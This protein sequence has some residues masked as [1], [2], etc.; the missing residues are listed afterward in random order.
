MTSVAEVTAR[1]IIRMSRWQDGSEYAARRGIAPVPAEERA[2][3]VDVL[4]P[5]AVVVRARMIA[6]PKMLRID[7]YPFG[8][9]SI[10]RAANA[11]DLEAELKRAGWHFFLMEPAV[12][13]WGLG[14]D[15]SAV[16]GRALRKAVSVAERENLNALQIKSIRFRRILGVHLVR[17]SVYARQVQWSREYSYGGCAPV[18]RPA[19]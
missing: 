3:L 12:H 18:F 1:P 10:L 14:V 16:L 11:L 17:L 6:L 2:S 8:Y 5:G 7:G 19:A 4:H 9:W 15:P 13:T